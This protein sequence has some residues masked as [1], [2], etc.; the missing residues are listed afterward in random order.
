VGALCSR[1]IRDDKNVERD[2]FRI[3]MVLKYGKKF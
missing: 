1:I 3:G 2:K